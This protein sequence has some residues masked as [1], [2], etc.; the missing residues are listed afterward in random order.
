[1]E[2]A[3]GIW[4]KWITNLMGAVLVLTLGRDEGKSGVV[5][6]F[7]SPRFRRIFPDYLEFLAFVVEGANSAE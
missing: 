5:I 4:L 7:P 3:I 2:G 1:M 6:D